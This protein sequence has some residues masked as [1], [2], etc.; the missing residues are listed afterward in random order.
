MMFGF[1]A[2]AIAGFLL[3]AMPSWTGRQGYSGRPLALLIALWLAGRTAVGAW[4]LF[5]E[6]A[7]AIDLAFF[8]GLALTLAPALIRARSFRN[9]P[10]LVILAVLFAANALFHAEMLGWTKETAGPGLLLAINTV[11]V[12]VVI[13][14]GRIITLNWL[15][16]RGKSVT[17]GP[18]QGLYWP[19]SAPPSSCSPSI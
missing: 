10:F 7:A 12:L 19:P 18:I 9:L 13:V 3:T 14:G 5:A 1:V 8:P 15:R 2:A 11:L 16:R 4:G 6:A 17:V